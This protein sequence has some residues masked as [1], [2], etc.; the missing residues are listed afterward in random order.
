MSLALLLIHVKIPHVEQSSFICI[1]QDLPQEPEVFTHEIKDQLGPNANLS[2]SSTELPYS[3]RT[4]LISS[5]FSPECLY[6][7]SCVVLI[8]TSSEAYLRY[9]IPDLA[10]AHFAASLFLVQVYLCCVGLFFFFLD[11]YIYIIA[12]PLNSSPSLEE[13]TLPPLSF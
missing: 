3:Y 11:V 8:E 1:N 6:Y 13:Q 5:H 10:T 9:V 12:D 2:L 4:R 7:S